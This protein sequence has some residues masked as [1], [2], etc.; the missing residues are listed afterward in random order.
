MAISS[1]DLTAKAELI[2]L[3]ELIADLRAA[4]PPW[5]PLLVGAMARDLLL[6]HAHNIPVRRA[7]ADIDIAFTVA[8]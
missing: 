1:L 2:F 4:A 7:T 6:F 5:E 3:A 8:D